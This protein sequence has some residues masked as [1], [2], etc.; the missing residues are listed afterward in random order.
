MILNIYSLKKNTKS[1]HFGY[2]RTDNCSTC[3]KLM[4]Q[5]DAATGSERQQIQEALEAHQLLAQEDY[6]TFRQDKELIS[7]KTWNHCK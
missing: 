2:P 1:V 5:T 3:D 4:I 7:R 6:Q